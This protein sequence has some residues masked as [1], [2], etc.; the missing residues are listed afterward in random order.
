MVKFGN[1][2]FQ[3]IMAKALR[4]LKIPFIVIAYNAKTIFSFDNEEGISTLPIF[5]D[6]EKAEKFR[7][8]FARKFKLKL[9]IC[10]VDSVEK[11]LNLIE[12]A[13]MVCK[14]L[15]NVVID[16]PPPSSKATQPPLR[17]IQTVINSLQGRYRRQKASIRQSLHKK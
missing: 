16:P 9:Q 4:L 10:V 14:T 3:T 15:Q 5:I 6:A 12:C 8:Y 1:D 13:S 11:G 17:P 2:V 7:R